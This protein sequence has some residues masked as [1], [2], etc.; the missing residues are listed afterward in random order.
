MGVD[1]TLTLP[2]QTS[3]RDVATVFGI[4]LGHEKVQMPLGTIDRG[5]AVRVPAVDINPA[6][7]IPACVYITEPGDFHLY[8]FEFNNAGHRGM[9]RRSTPYNIALWCAMAD[10][11]GGTV[12][13]NDCDEEFADYVVEPPHAERPESDE[14]WQAW[15]E[16]L[17]SVEPLPKN[18][19]SKFKAVAAY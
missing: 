18:A 6:P 8:H 2:P 16:R 15:Q 7:N 10:V 13:F 11:F 19:G 9:M 14:A 4:L 5:W 3:V 1:T 12:D 17:W